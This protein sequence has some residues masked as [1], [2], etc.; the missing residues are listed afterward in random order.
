MS[1][2]HSFR[3]LCLAVAMAAAMVLV[4]PSSPALADDNAKS[5]LV[6]NLTTDD[7]WTNQMALGLAKRIA[8]GGGTVVVFLNV[9]A[10]SL[11]SKNVPPATGGLSGKTA[12][13]MLKALVDAGAD[14][15]LC[16]SC[17]KQAGL[18]MEDRIEGVKPGSQAF[19]DVLMAPGTR[20]MSY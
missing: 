9:R 17:T 4:Q 2:S 16:P 3:A 5:T 1:L 15:Y 13:E 12:H 8:D 14:V 19:L 20:V 18:N 6:F 10:V 11:A 7:V